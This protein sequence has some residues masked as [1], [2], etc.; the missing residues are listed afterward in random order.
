MAKSI[1]A[2]VSSKSDK[3][4]IFVLYGVDGVGKTSLAAEWPNPIYLNTTGE[5]TPNDI[6]LPT[7]GE[8]ESY[9]DLVD[10]IGELLSTD[11]GF[12]T[13]I[14]DSMDGL[15]PLVW[16]ETCRRLGVPSIE[17]PGFGKGYVEADKEWFNLLDGFA[18]LK[19]AGIGVVLLA[20]PHIDRF[21]SPTSDP[22]S[23]Y[24]LKLHKRARGFVREKADVV[25][26]VNYRT[27][28]KE[29]EVARQTKVAH[30]EG[31][32]ER[33]IH[34]EERPGFLAKNRYSMPASVP[35]KKGKGYAALA[36]YFPAPRA[37]NDNVQVEQKEAA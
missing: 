8:I 16:A 4:P 26:F 35:F 22:Y 28:L 1:S 7:P 9:G 17:T 34:L 14:I 11:H 6:E 25:A 27:T 10:Y 33:N 12:Q 23:R 31:S 30:G 29:K 20:H 5:E 24:D 21:D 2:L 19:K 32:G 37:A 13:V 15:E 3:P 36:Q 18:H